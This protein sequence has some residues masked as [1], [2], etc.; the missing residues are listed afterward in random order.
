M[1]TASGRSRGASATANASVPSIAWRLGASSWLLLLVFGPGGGV[2]WV[3]FGILS[4]IGRRLSWGIASGVYGLAAIIV[5]IPEEPVG[6]IAQG[7]LYLVALLHGLIINHRWL[8]L[9]WGRHENGLTLIGTPRGSKPRARAATPRRRKTAIP[10]EAEAL[11]GGDGTAKSD[12]VDESAPEPA[13]QR[14]G[15]SRAQRRAQAA[16]EARADTRAAAARSEPATPAELIDVNTANQ[17][18]LAR[19]TGLDRA[20]AKA[21]IAE[22]TS[23]GGFA[24]LEAFASSAGL[25]PHELVR[26]RA[27]AYCS[28]R[29]RADRSFGR[30]VDY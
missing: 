17:R 18:T 10:K 19:L 22:R 4:L 3:A 7:S 12:Y 28:P 27:E 21:A 15:L 25:Q 8:L 1:T 9:L 5:R 23:R 30:R 29:P 24:S 13:P 11:L 2:A 20:R 26:L 14:R 6:G 16:A